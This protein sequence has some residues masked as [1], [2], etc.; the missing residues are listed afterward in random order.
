MGVENFFNKAASKMIAVVAES[1][2]GEEKLY[3]EE[4]SKIAEAEQRV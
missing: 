3:L 1:V 4:Q 2:E